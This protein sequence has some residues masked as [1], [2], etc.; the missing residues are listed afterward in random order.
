MNI[1]MKGSAGVTIDGK[2]F[3]GNNISIKNG[4]VIVDNVVQ[5]GELTGDVNVVVHGDVQTLRNT[6]GLITAEHVGSIN[7]VSGDVNCLGVE[8]SIQTVSG[9]VN[10]AMVSGSI[11]TVSGDVRHK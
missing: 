9:D 5:D 1:N 3:S 4:K 11:K 2:T 8:G 6:S 7:T 10:C